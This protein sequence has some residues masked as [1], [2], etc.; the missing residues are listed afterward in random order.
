MIEIHNSKP[1]K[2]VVSIG[3]DELTASMEIH[4]GKSIVVKKRKRDQG[5]DFKRWT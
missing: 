1:S 4:T 3:F 5:E 2:S